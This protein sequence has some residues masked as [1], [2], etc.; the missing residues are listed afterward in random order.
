MLAATDGHAKNLSIRLL[1]QGRYRLTPLYD[2]LSA[3]PITGPGPN[4]V[5]RKKLK[6]AM[7]VRG[8]H[9]HY[10]IDEIDRRHFNAT[11]R[12]C[13]LGRDM[14]AIIDDV[15][16]RT[17]RIIDEVGADLPTGFPA[18]VFDVITK[19]TTGAAERLKRN[20]KS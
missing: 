10:W 5:H 6:L 20:C 18:R 9:K 15:V 3:W 8:T 4:Q 2:V 7:A 17:P 13:G 19:G 1:A 14:D 11:A 16:D 12:L